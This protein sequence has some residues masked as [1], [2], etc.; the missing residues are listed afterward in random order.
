[1]S[2]MQDFFVDS[3]QDAEVVEK[4]VKIGGKE[5]VMKFKAISAAKGD[6][7]RKSCRKVTTHKGVKLVETDQ[8]AFLAKLIIETTLYPDLKNKELQQNWGV[9]GAEA[10]LDAMKARMWDGE[11]GELVQIAQEVNGYNSDLS[12][13]VEEVKN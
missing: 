6:E 7:I 3:F 11:Y 1:M 5:R 13:M 4:V 12:D 2:D 9:I 8:D 10:L